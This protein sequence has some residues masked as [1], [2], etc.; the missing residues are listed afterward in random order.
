MAITYSRF[1]LEKRMLR[2]GIKYILRE[3]KYSDIGMLNS[4]HDLSVHSSSLEG[5]ANL[6]ELRST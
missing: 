5:E 1:T 3:K 4:I 2:N 6:V